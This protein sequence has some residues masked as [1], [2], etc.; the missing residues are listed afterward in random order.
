MKRLL[1]F[2]F[3][4]ITVNSL[5]AQNDKVKVMNFNQFEPLLHKENGKFI[6][7]FSE[8]KRCPL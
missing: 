1:I 2:V 8:T 5:N 3:L 4:L 7:F 6:D